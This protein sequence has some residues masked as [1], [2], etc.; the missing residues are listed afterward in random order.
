LG[1][2]ILDALSDSDLF[3]LLVAIPVFILKEFWVTWGAHV[4]EWGLVSLVSIVESG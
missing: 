3:C 1:S 2:V 4:V